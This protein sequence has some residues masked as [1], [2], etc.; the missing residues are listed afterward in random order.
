MSIDP[1]LE[2]EYNARAS[3]PDH[4]A[5]F[6]RWAATSAEAR[7]KLDATIDIQYGSGP[8]ATLDIFPSRR[9]SAPLLVFIHGGYWRSLD[10]SDF[11]FLAPSMLDAGFA[12]AMVN[13]D[14]CPD[15]SLTQIVGQSRAALRWLHGH[16][17]AFG[18]DPGQL[19]LAGHS[20]GGHLVAMLFATD[21][22]SEGNSQLGAAI[23]AGFALSGLYDLPPLRSTSVQ[24]DIRL[25]QREAELLSPA[26]LTPSVTAPLKLAVGECESH[27][28][29]HN[30]QLLHEQWAN[31]TAPTIVPDA[32]HLSIVDRLAD[33]ASGLLSSL[34]GRN[35]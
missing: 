17:D 33:P 10:K 12:V 15:A 30:S 9:E 5:I 20:A 21:W 1:Q 6:E 25:D 28:F 32:H 11:S 13:Y 27:A 26:L 35:A 14:L 22:A 24:Q 29:R 8:L 7:G 19:H 18:Y 3:I 23:R 4:P 34:T 2:A 31:C 16:A